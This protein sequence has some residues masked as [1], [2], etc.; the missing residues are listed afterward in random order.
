[1]AIL[2]EPGDRKDNP[3]ARDY[4][5]FLSDEEAAETTTLNYEI[6]PPPPG[7]TVTVHMDNK[8]NSLRKIHSQKRNIKH[9]L[10]TERCQ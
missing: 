6:R 5:D 2:S 9:S 1:M 4:D 8:H 3:T 10:T 7:V